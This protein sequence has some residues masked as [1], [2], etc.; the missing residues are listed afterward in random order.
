[1][2]ILISAADAMNNG[3]ALWLGTILEQDF[4]AGRPRG[5]AHSF[6]LKSGKDVIITAITVLSY[7]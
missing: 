2:V 3:Y 1:V 5:V 7:G 6:K 4:A